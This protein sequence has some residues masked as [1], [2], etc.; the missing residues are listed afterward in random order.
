[1][2]GAIIKVMKRYG[3]EEPEA[4]GMLRH[5]ARQRRT[6][7]ESIAPGSPFS[8]RSWRRAAD[9]LSRKTRG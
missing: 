6:T 4:F 1:V 2:V 9:R 3:V 7:I 5:A 8:R